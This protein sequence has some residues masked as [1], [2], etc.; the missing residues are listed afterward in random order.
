[1]LTYCDHTVGLGSHDWPWHETCCI[2]GQHGQCYWI[3]DR[4]DS[5]NG[6]T[7]QEMHPL[8]SG[9]SVV[10][11]QGQGATLYNSTSADNVRWNM[12]VVSGVVEG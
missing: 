2:L 8:G 5:H 3:C 10:R 11:L 4:T 7:G 12:A 6:N 9:W 1:M